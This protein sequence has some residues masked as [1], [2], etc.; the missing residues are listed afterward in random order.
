MAR[1]Q[2]AVLLPLPVPV[3]TIRRPFS[4]GL[5]GVEP[6]LGGLDPGHLGAVL[7]LRVRRLLDHA[8]APLM[9]LP[10]CAAEL[11]EQRQG[12]VAAGLPE[13]ALDRLR[14][15]LRDLAQRRRVGLGD[16]AAH[17]LVAEIGVEQRVEMVVARPRPSVAAKANR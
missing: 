2:A 10:P 16:E 13:A 12:A 9:V 8:S 4:P 1:P 5:A 7:G 3:W 11:V 14:E 6:V 17:R 15:P